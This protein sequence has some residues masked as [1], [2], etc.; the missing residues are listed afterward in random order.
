MPACQSLLQRTGSEVWWSV[1]VHALPV[2]P[3]AAT[4]LQLA[5][6]GEQKGAEWCP[7]HAFRIFCTAAGTLQ[8]VLWLLTPL[9]LCAQTRSRAQILLTAR[10]HLQ[11][12]W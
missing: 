2:E 3:P 10:S 5:H 12:M 7:V 8:G 1:C 6:L 4:C 9:L 11:P